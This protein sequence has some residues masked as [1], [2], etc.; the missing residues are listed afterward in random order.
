MPGMNP[1]ISEI[2]A[3][4]EVV[5]DTRGP[6]GKNWLS[7][8]IPAAGFDFSD[9]CCELKHPEKINGMKQINQRVNLSQ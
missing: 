5:S 3:E 7:A 1:A 2:P 4:S 9:A 8:V 6:D